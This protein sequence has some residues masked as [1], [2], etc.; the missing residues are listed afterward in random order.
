MVLL[1]VSSACFSQAFPL[2]PGHWEETA[3]VTPSRPAAPPAGPA[4]DCL[5]D[6]TWKSAITPGKSCSVSQFTVTASGAHYFVECINPGMR[7]KGEAEVVFY[8]K[9]HMVLK[10]TA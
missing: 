4:W 8:G 6:E 2:R 1:L 10:S 9:E 7:L 3:T 5:N